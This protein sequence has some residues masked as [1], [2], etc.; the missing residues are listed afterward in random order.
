MN[1]SIVREI[2]LSGFFI[3]LGLVLPSAFHAFV[4]IIIANLAAAIFSRI[5]QA[6]NFGAFL[7][8]DAIEIDRQRGR[9]R[10]IANLGAS[11][12]HVILR[13]AR[14]RDEEQDEA[15]KIIE[16]DAG[17]K[18]DDL[19]PFGDP[20]KGPAGWGD[21]F[22]VIGNDGRFPIHRA[23]TAKGESADREISLA[24]FFLNVEKLRA[25]ANRIFKAINFE[26]FGHAQVPGL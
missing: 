19:L 2:A 20:F 15:K 6:I 21:L 3:A 16:G 8:I 17:D 4:Q 12:A 14:N 22:D 10:R 1:N 26:E 7:V 25:E 23:I 18:N 11:R 5:D 9:G 24:A 13:E